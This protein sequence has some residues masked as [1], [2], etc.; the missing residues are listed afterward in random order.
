MEIGVW[1]T[2]LGVFMMLGVTD[3]PYPQRGSQTR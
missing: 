2:P 3:S 1:S